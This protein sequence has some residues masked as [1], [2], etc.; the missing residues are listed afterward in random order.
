[1]VKVKSIFFNWIFEI[2]SP[3]GKLEF[4]F[5]LFPTGHLKLRFGISLGQLDQFS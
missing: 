3:A 5:P 1:M 4:Y 2:V